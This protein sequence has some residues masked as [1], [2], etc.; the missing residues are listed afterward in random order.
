MV[1]SGHLQ[2]VDDDYWKL[3]EK[4]KTPSTSRPEYWKDFLLPYHKQADVYLLM[5]VQ[6][7]K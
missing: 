3:F 6:L 7:F 2:A 5:V 4:P 1:S